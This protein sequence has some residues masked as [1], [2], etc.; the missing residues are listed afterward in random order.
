MSVLNRGML[1]AEVRWSDQGRAGLLFGDEGAA[2]VL[3]K[4]RRFERL[5]VNADVHMRRPNGTAYRVR[6]YDV[7][8]EGCG[9]DDLDRYRLDE[10]VWIRFEGLEPLE[11]KLR[12][13]SNFRAGLRFVRPIHPAVF[14]LLARRLKLEGKLQAE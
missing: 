11:T 1:K 8:P 13:R 5:L 4:T 9:V 10:S 6:V 2:G 14:E 7:S 3:Q 12:W